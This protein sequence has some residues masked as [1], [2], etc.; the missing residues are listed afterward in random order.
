MKNRIMRQKPQRIGS[1][2]R[3]ADLPRSDVGT[4]AEHGGIATR[5]T[6]PDGSVSEWHAIGVR[7]PGR[8]DLVWLSGLDLVG[9]A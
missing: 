8:A 6:H 4:V 3:L 7:Y 1:R 5:Y 2:V 9:A